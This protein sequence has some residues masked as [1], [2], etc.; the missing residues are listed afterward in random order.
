[1]F[2]MT[3]DDLAFETWHHSDFVIEHSIFATSWQLAA[4]QCQLHRNKDIEKSN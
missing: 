4:R 2:L 3:S 1:M